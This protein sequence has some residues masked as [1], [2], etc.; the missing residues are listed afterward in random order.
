MANSNP[1]LGRDTVDDSNLHVLHSKDPE[2]TEIRHDGLLSVSSITPGEPENVDASFALPASQS[3]TP[4]PD[5]V[6][7]LVG[8][9]LDHYR[10]ESLVGVGGMGAVFRGRDQR[11][12]R[13]V[14]IKVVPI[15]NRR[16]DAMR[17]F[18]MEAQSAAKLDHPNIARVYYVGETERWSYIVFE[19][20]EGTNLRQLVLEHGLLTV[21]DATRFICQ[22]AEALQH[23]HDRGVVH[24][25][26]KPSNILIGTDGKAKLVDMG[27]ARTTELDRST[28][29]LTASGVTLG[30]FDYISPEQAHDPRDADVRSDIYSLGCTLYFLLTGQP[31][32]P[33]GTA[34]Q[35]LL[36]HGTKM[37]EDPRFFRNDL[38]DS[39]IEILRK[40]MAKKPKDRYQTPNDL[41]NDL[42]TLAVVDSLSWSQDFNDEVLASS[43]SKRP[44]WESAMPSLVSLLVI[45]LST[46]WLYNANQLN[47]IFSIPQVEFAD[48]SPESNLVVASASNPSSLVID[49]PNSADAKLRGNTEP[50]N[51]T[52][53]EGIEASGRSASDP[54]EDSKPVGEATRDKTVV[55]GKPGTISGIDTDESYLFATSIDEAF[56]R[57]INDDSIGRLLVAE[58]VLSVGKPIDLAGLRKGREVRI[59]AAPGTRARIVFDES[60][61]KSSNEGESE[62]FALH[63]GKVSFHRMDFIW[64]AS[65]LDSRPQSMFGSGSGSHL[66]WN[67]C[68]I[69]V[70]HQGSLPLPSVVRNIGSK[71]TFDL[72]SNAVGGASTTARDSVTGRETVTG[73]D[74]VTGASSLSMKR[75]AIRGQCDWC[76]TDSTERMDVAVEQSW[77]SISG[78]MLLADGV[79]TLNR[80]PKLRLELDHVSCITLSP[81]VRIRM[82]TMNAF[83]IAF[84]R[85]ANESVFAGASTLVEWDASNCTDWGFAAQAKRVE[86]LGRWIDLR[87]LDNSYDV[88]SI[89]RLVQVIMSMSSEEVAIDSDSNLLMNERGM[90]LLSTWQ[91]GSRV[92][93]A[94]M[95]LQSPKLRPG[96]T[97]G[98]QQGSDPE[99]LPPLPN[100]L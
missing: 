99:K 64:N 86:D 69:T 9:N 13:I 82:S 27:L 45:A 91:S 72:S 88:L 66:D 74:S 6:D 70:Q 7:S 25:D 46:M 35:K 52:G 59:E 90:E 63:G 21:D 49:N 75:C 18:R 39:L 36:M 98:V 23:A 50:R 97:V 84:V 1:S 92:D 3:S 30:T 60:S 26:I 87:G 47:A 29:D 24:R 76:H 48:A 58:P 89:S 68:T 93:G 96:S 11:L 14:A 57:I 62:W 53:S 31:P 32:F 83:P 81:F 20:I 56:S 85:V 12:D 19:F 33:D 80:S 38:S 78:S 43:Q 37:P 40:M 61:I 51:R 8:Q 22:V 2:K 41:V 67:E 71:G 100:M 79:K 42:R 4:S 34:L 15:S 55:I 94:K 95:H 10:I 54:T 73:R 77:I 16:A 44:W 5:S 17:R 28:G 65:M